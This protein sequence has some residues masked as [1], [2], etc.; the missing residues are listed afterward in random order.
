MLVLLFHFSLGLLM[1]AL[2]GVQTLF[3]V[4]LLLPLEAVFGT[5]AGAPIGMALWLGVGIVLQ[6]GYLG[7]ALIRSVLERFATAAGLRTSSRT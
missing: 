4:V 1:G 2:F 5:I 7:G 3:L 6:L